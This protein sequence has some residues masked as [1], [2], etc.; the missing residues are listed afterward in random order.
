MVTCHNCKCECKRFGYF[1]PQ[2]IQRY[3]CKQCGKCFSDLPVRPL[4]TLRTPL[5]KAVQIVAMLAEGVGIRATARLAGVHRDTVLAILEV[6][7]EK[8]ARLLDE[9][10]RDVQVESVQADEL[11][12]F[13]YCKQY[14]NLSGDPERG[15]Q[16]T[17][18]AID[19]RSKLILSY[20]VGKRDADH[21][22]IFVADL[23]KRIKGRAQ[24]TTDGM[25]SYLGAITDT[26]GGD[27]DFAQQIKTYLNYPTTVQDH[28]RYSSFGVKSVRTLVHIGEPERNKISTSHVER[29]NLSV[30]LFT[31]RFT[32]LTLGYSKT[33]ANLKHAVALFV[34]HFNFCRVHSA[35]KQT[36]A[37]AA[38][39][40]DH[41]WTVEELFKNR[42]ESPAS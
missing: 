34:A 28:R 22:D 21:T 25:Q 5:D 32:R 26:F 18:L 20:H 36:P 14:N 7:G 29:T 3:R 33:L 1:G 19:R 2:R 39:L 13:V 10:V 9:K 27:V 40:T 16:Y 6:I 42:V 35:H 37:H 23:R 15:E 31:R 4:D 12:A 30:R 24:V 8:C 17:F 41:A 11:F 38:G